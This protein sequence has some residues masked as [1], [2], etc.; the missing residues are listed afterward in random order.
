MFAG[1][2]QL[3]LDISSF[4]L[5]NGLKVVLNRD[6]TFN[7]VALYLLGDG[8][9][10]K[11]ASGQHGLAHLFEHVMLPTRWYH[12]ALLSR[13][14]SQHNINSNAQ[15]FNDY[16]RY[17]LHYD[18]NG[19]DYGLIALADRLDFQIDSLTDEGL[20]RHINNVASEISRSESFG[21]FR[22]HPVFRD[23]LA[24]GVFGAI[25][26]YGHEQSLTDISHAT[27]KDIFNWYKRWYGAGNSTLLVIGNVHPD[28]LKSKVQTY[29]GNIDPGKQS[30]QAEVS[31]PVFKEER[32]VNITFNK[33]KHIIYFA[34]ATPG[35]GTK[36]EDHLRL[37]SFMLADPSKGILMKALKA[38]A[39]ENAK[40]FSSIESYKEASVFDAG[41]EFSNW[42]QREKVEAIIRNE[43][44][45]LTTS[46]M[47]AH[48]IHTAYSQYML[49]FLKSIEDIGVN[50]ERVAELGKGSMF[51]NNPSYFETRSQRLSKLKPSQLQQSASNW[52]KNAP[53]VATIQGRKLAASIQAYDFKT[54]IPFVAP[55]PTAVL[56]VFQKQVSDRITV[57]AVTLSRI[58]VVNFLVFFENAQNEPAAETVKYLDALLKY[59]ESDPSFTSL[60]STGLQTEGKVIGKNLVYK[61]SVAKHDATR[62]YDWL[63]KRLKEF[64]NLD[65]TANTEDPSSQMQR[66]L[67]VLK[68]LMVPSNTSSVTFPLAR[69]HF[70]AVG[71]L[72][73]SNKLFDW[74]HLAF[75]KAKFYPVAASQVTQTEPA[76]L[77]VKDIGETPTTFLT[78][79]HSLK[80]ANIKEEIYQ[81]L[82]VHILRAKLMANLREKNSLT[83]EVYPY[84]TTPAG[85]QT[86]AFWQTSVPIEK[87]VRTLEEIA[88]ELEQLPIDLERRVASGKAR[89]MADLKSK[90][91]T[92]D[93]IEN[94]VMELIEYD[95]SANYFT[96]VLEELN[97]VDAAGFVDFVKQ[98]ARSQ[99]FKI[100]LFTTSKV[101][102]ELIEKGGSVKTIK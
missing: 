73:P 10:K 43:I 16:V 77:L 84:N 74:T 3:K 47:P 71:D 34:W 95:R 86:L 49:S 89:V 52:L 8:G 82:I 72:D 5:T 61:A 101:V 83:Y 13:N 60:Q 14:A 6:T 32:K 65:K 26:P 90:F 64:T 57:H 98:K 51:V 29:F 30:I 53:F 80:P 56:P 48:H 62:V 21:S 88:N 69:V 31:V 33:D 91:K 96:K 19:L 54:T 70:I 100:A 76:N 7:E 20:Q 66:T 4:E 11:E 63:V 99:D 22:W 41:V 23:A 75:N 40:P 9:F 85:N 35:Y 81:Q 97:A 36:D 78:L 38:A 27:K 50:D 18:K 79:A 1:R 17:Y 92:L 55:S 93:A 2:A 87:T 45:K 94:T 12:N 46:V 42:N 39:I 24:K 102:K 67:S 59:F 25:H 28:S 58:P 15:V 68:Q 44:Q 37:T